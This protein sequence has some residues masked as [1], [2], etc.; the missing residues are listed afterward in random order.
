[1]YRRMC[2]QYCWLGG[3]GL[4]TIKKGFIANILSVRVWWWW[5]VRPTFGEPLIIDTIKP[6]SLWPHTRILAADTCGLCVGVCGWW[7]HGSRRV[8]LWG[9][10]WEGGHSFSV[11]HHTAID[12]NAMMAKRTEER[13]LTLTT[14]I[15]W[16]YDVRVKRMELC[17]EFVSIWLRFECG[18]CC[19]CCVCCKQ[20]RY[21][22][23]WLVVM[24]EKQVFERC[25]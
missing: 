3:G 9:G 1:M 19:C 16:L 12:R 2:L 13:N 7:E 22:G 17:V 10:W 18:C 23:V 4:A 14:T 8:F 20:L 21:S 11:G 15:W 25:A 24:T 5:A 6:S